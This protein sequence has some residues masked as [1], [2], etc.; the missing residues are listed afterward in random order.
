MEGMLCKVYLQAFWDFCG[1]WKIRKMN[2][3]FKLHYSLYM[4][5]KVVLTCLSNWVVVFCFCF[6]VLLMWRNKVSSWDKNMKQAMVFSHYD[7]PLLKMMLFQI[8]NSPTV[9]LICRLNIHIY[10]FVYNSFSQVLM[11]N[12][13]HS[14][15]RFF[16]T[17]MSELVVNY[18]VNAG[19]NNIEN[20]FKCIK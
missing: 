12:R 19:H 1:K 17:S 4:K 11:W 2:N 16:Y 10:H 7:L 6:S 13:H 18:C 20:W 15:S 3:D 9:F 5:I 14:D 8:R